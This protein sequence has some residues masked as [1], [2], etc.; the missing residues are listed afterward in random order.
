[1]RGLVN[2]IQGLSRESGDLLAKGL[3]DNLSKGVREIS[4]EGLRRSVDKLGRA[5]RTVSLDGSAAYIGDVGGELS[6]QAQQGN[7][8]LGQAIVGGVNSFFIGSAARG[9]F[10]R[11]QSSTRRTS[12]ARSQCSSRC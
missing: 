5:G 2:G 8:D 4:T 1:M 9:H 3:V 12:S 7:V 10:G 6:R 11:N